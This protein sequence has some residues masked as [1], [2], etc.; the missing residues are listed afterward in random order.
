P[1][2]A[3]SVQAA[4]LDILRLWHGARVIRTAGPAMVI[5][6]IRDLLAAS[7]FI[8]LNDPHAV[9]EAAG[10]WVD[11][12]LLYIDRAVFAAEIALEDAPGR[13]AKILCDKGLLV[14]GGEQSSLQYKLPASL[15]PSRPRTYRIR[16]TRL[17]QM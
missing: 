13:T 8:D 3:G 6:R 9:P 10:G 4:G 16:R 12:Q 15:V 7:R 17:A 11:A 14:P 2:P 5:Q 1:W